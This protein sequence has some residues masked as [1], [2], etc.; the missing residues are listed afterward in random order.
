MGT[1]H[2]PPIF[3]VITLA[4]VFIP[5]TFGADPVLTPATITDKYGNKANS[6]SNITWAP[7]PSFKPY[8]TVLTYNDGGLAP[9]FNFARSFI[10]TAMPDDFPYGEIYRKLFFNK[11][12]K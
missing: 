9:L 1:R 8:K 12:N 10:D 6:A 7:V 3:G 5:Y 11:I 4:L 2:L